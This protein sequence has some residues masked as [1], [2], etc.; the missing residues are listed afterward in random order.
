M[1]LSSLL[2]SGCCKVVRA[3]EKA[4]QDDQ[5]AETNAHLQQQLD[6]MKEQQQLSAVREAG[7]LAELEQVQAQL[8][9]HVEKSRSLEQ[10]ADSGAAAVWWSLLCCACCVVE[11]LCGACCVLLVDW[12]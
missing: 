5:A 10:Q 2:T 4:S 8:S 9:E 6:E 3:D 7:L 1:M 11:L 12:L